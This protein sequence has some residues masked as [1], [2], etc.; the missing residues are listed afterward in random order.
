MAVIYING[1]KVECDNNLTI[2][3]ATKNLEDIYIPTLCHLDLEAFNIEHHIGSCRVCMVDVEVDGR[4]KMMPSCATPV[5]D[6]MIIHTNTPEV[7]HTRRTVL[8]LILSDHPFECLT[9]SKNGNC[10]LQSLAKEFG[11]TE[12][13]YKGKKKNY[14]IDISSKAI[15]RDLN[16]C[17]MCRRCE[18]AC[19][20]LQTVGTLSGYKRGF[21]AVVAPAN[22]KPL[23]D[24]NCTFCGQC[25]NVCPTAA[26]TEISYINDVWRVLNDKSKKVIVQTAPAVRVGICEEFCLD[27]FDPANTGKL[28]TGLR[29][30]GF[31]TVFDTNFSAD[32]TIMEEANEFIQRLTKGGRLPMLT[33]CCPGW[34]NFLEHNFP[35]LIDIPSTCKSPQQM[36]GAIAKTYYANKIGIDPKDLIVVSIM[37]CLAKKYE[38]G[39]NE[40]KRNNIPDV[41]Y[42][43]TTRELAVMFREAGI[44]PAKLQPSNYDSPLGTSTGAA[45][46]FG[47]TGG[48]VEA[49]LRTA[50]EW[51]TNEKLEQIDF[52]EVRG[53]QGI[54]EA[55]IDIKGT[56]V[57]IAVTSGL[58]NARKI[59]EKIE[60]G[61]A[62]YHL[63]EIMA[64]PGGCINGGGQPYIHG[65]THKIVERLNAIYSIDEKSVIRKSHEN[66]DI[67]KLYQEF[68]GEPGSHKAHELLHTN[69]FNREMV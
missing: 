42:V 60:S 7:I 22:L 8:E 57:K 51:I 4:R 38:A 62:D 52:K 69:Y 36:F 33:S 25:V 15:K 29:M 53:L 24:T 48:V 10:E 34:I 32:L 54:K 64:C 13:S 37:P 31:D 17:I 11:I 2:L 6:G 59:L 43:L 49:A 23:I 9:C 16:K 44:N 46:I 20:I 14:A 47:V 68:L 21:E 61:E 3:E 65:D 55:T 1:N 27:H 56:K 39:R 66:P 40:F 18:T 30:L 12:I 28:V 26:L 19:N 35:D 50:Y 63:I 58:G 5:K 45:A 41:D 67:I